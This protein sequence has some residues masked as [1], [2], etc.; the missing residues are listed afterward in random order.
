M[1]INIKDKCKDSDGFKDFILY[2][3]LVYIRSR[4][5]ADCYAQCHDKLICDYLDKFGKATRGGIDKL[6]KDKLSDALDTSQKSN[7][8]ANLLTKMRRNG[9]I[10]NRASR[11]SPEWHFAGRK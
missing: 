1:F 10:V 7:K 8:I 3:L 9:L 5:Q 11:T 4:F 6:I 2:F